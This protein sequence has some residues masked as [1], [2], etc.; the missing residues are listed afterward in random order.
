MDWTKEELIRTSKVKK[1]NDCMSCEEFYEAM[2]VWVAHNRELRK[3]HRGRR[4]LRGR[5]PLVRC[6]GIKSKASLSL[7]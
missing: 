2:K 1:V 6:F 7:Q 3:S 5:K 4:G